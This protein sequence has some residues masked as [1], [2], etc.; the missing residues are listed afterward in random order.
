MAQK[1]KNNPE[2]R[3]QSNV[4]P[5]RKVST[6]IVPEHFPEPDHIV[7]PTYVY[8][9]E[10]ILAVRGRQT[11]VLVSDRP[12]V[13]TG[14][15]LDNHGQGAQLQ[16]AWQ[17][18]PGHGKKWKRE[19]FPK[20]QLYDTRTIQGLLS[21]RGLNVSSVNAR[22]VVVYLQ[23]Y[24]S[25]NRQA[26]KHSKVLTQCGWHY[27]GDKPV[28]FLLGD[29]LLRTKGCRDRLS[30]RPNTA[31]EHQVI[32]GISQAGSLDEWLRVAK[33][34]ARYPR[35]ALLL[36]ASFSS[37]LVSLLGLDGF[38]VDLSYRTSTGKSTAQ[39]LAASVWGDP[40]V[41]KGGYVSG[42]ESKRV[43][44]E[45]KAALLQH[46]ALVLDDTKRA[47]KEHLTDLIYDL[48]AGS[49][50]VRGG[51]EGMAK[52]N[53]W[54]LVIVS[55]GEQPITSYGAEHGGKMARVLPIWGAPF[56][57]VSLK[58]GQFAQRIESSVKSHHGVAGHAWIRWLLAN[59]VNQDQWKEFVLDSQQKLAS[60]FVAR[61]VDG[62]LG[63]RLARHLSVLMLTGRLVDKALGVPYGLHDG[64]LPDLFVGLAN[65]GPAEAK[66]FEAILQL[67][68]FN[69]IRF[70]PSDGIPK[71]VPYGGFWGYRMSEKPFVPAWDRRAIDAELTRL[72]YEPDAML[73]L[74][75]EL[76]YIE[77][78]G[79]GFTKRVRIPTKGD[80]VRLVVFSAKKCQ[81]VLGA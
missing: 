57:V 63:T 48:A 69:L 4:V 73:R 64:A 24:E 71:Q 23:A 30:L 47:P 18:D 43:G 41:K 40:N 9:P 66:A 61:G 54:N 60:L 34:G 14:F 62:G 32:K 65:E 25:A 17:P 10:G 39:F 38:I 80:R 53:H 56:G 20:R 21:D 45:Q 1:S 67:A 16:L 13:I 49:G 75:K 22:E 28:A 5:I 55:T 50:R 8:G 52:Q 6:T 36:Y 79:A 15:A 78:D 51:L 12:L 44:L 37:P 7:P 70:E 77:T 46:I 59:L 27:H 81:Q 68:L 42:W 58:A 35:V 19:F 2:P 33:L 31:G 74:W 72:G 26:I 3:K 29:K 76:G 11:P